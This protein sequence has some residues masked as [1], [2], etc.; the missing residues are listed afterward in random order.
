MTV[1]ILS[2]CQ[3]KTLGPI[4]NQGHHFLSGSWRPFDGIHLYDLQ[5]NFFQPL[6]ITIQRYNAI[7]FKAAYFILQTMTDFFFQPFQHCEPSGNPYYL[8]V[9]NNNIV[10]ITTTIMV[11]IKINN[12][13][14]ATLICLKG[15]QS[16]VQTEIRG[17]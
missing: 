8:T 16:K 9:K 10:V 1:I 7:G 15:T 17:V 13:Y 11:I 6:S 3:L 4:N 12:T 5:D 14:N 2:H